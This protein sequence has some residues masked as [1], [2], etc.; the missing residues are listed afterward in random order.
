MAENQILTIE[1]KRIDPNPVYGVIVGQSDSLILI[2][3]EYNLQFDGYIVI[4]RKDV[5]KSFSSDSNDYS[6]QLMKLEGWWEPVPAKIKKLPL[7]SWASLLRQFVGKAVILQNERTEDFYIGPVT[8]VTESAVVT[9]YFD[10]CGEWMDPERIPFS[11]ITSMQFGD[12]YST[13][14]AKHLKK[15]TGFTE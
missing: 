14:Y 4:R 5:T 7:D 13:T 10:G 12:R 6:A 3:H 11:K 1:R 15:P 2:H 9:H 8:D